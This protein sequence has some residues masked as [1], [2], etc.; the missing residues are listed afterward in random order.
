MKVKTDTFGSCPG[1]GRHLKRK[2]HACSVVCATAVA[3]W[4][5]QAATEQRIK[6]RRVLLP[7][8]IDTTNGKQY[9]ESR[10]DRRGSTHH[11]THDPL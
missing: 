7:D 2:A 6:R 3:Y 1:C 8:A 10:G 9:N 11:R 4:R 5:R